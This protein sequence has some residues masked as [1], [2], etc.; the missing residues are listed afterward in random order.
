M[1]RDALI[2]VRFIRAQR[3]QLTRRF[4]TFTVSVKFF[5]DISFFHLNTIQTG[6][7]PKEQP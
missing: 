1:G 6:K 2:Y 4:V 3:V 7:H 5:P